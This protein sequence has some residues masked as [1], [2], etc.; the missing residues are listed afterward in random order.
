MLNVSLGQELSPGSNFVLERCK[1]T[2]LSGN[3]AV[4]GALDG[5]IEFNSPCSVYSNIDEQYGDMNIVSKVI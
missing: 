5:D 4:N 3:G 1:P 2:H